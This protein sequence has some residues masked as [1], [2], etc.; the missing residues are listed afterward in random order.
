[1]IADFATIA[2]MA[3]P[4]DQV[5]IATRRIE[6][7]TRIQLGDT[8]LSLSH[9]VLDGHRFA[10]RSLEPGDVLTSWGQ[11]F[12]EVL[13]PIQPGDYVCNEAVLR[14]LARHSPDFALPAQPNFAD[15]IAPFRF[16]EMAFRPGSPPAPYDEPLTFEGYRRPGGRGVG[17]R[18]MIV[19][20]GTSSLT[21][22][23]VRVLETQLKGL[24]KPGSGIDGIVAAAHTEGGTDKPNNRDLLLRTLAGMIVHPNVGAVLIV[25]RG[26]EGIN[27]AVLRDYMEQHGYPLG[28]VIH[29]FIS[30]S[31]SFDDDC[32][33][34]AETV[35][36][37]LDSV[38]NMPR[39]TAPASELK[40]GLQCGGSDA[41]SGIS[42]NPLAAWVAREIIRYGGSANLAE[43]D[44]L[45]GAE[46]YVLQN[47]RDLATARKF[48][49]FVERFKTWTSWH[50]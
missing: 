36:A 37:W 41:F 23:F 8:S 49:A 7:G 22:G 6:Q 32:R 28:D 34:A 9:T 47:V 44:E 17:T 15:Q 14:E 11:P 20:L 4:E 40:I 50:G 2:R 26:S 12:G 27:N 35:R 18:N 42:G 39:S 21:S 16:D 24:A 45:I 10:V 48:L 43:T 30:L 19:L 5:A 29:R 25:D 3:S 38:M 46:S 33:S 31:R 1:M 13:V